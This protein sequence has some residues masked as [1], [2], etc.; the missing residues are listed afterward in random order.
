MD[1]GLPLRDMK[2]YRKVLKPEENYCSEYM[3]NS[4]EK[5]ETDLKYFERELQAEVFHVGRE[6][7]LIVNQHVPNQIEKK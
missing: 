3:D 6:A 4:E 7:S 1:T 5:F 2:L